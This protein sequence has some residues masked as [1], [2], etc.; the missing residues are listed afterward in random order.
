MA[1]PKTS[2]E[3]MHAL[4]REAG[5]GERLDRFI[6]LAERHTATLD[7]ALAIC[8]KY[9]GDFQHERI[10][11]Q[12]RQLRRRLMADLDHPCMA[13]PFGSLGEWG[14]NGLARTVQDTLQQALSFE[15]IRA[16]DAE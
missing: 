12:A 2:R 1:V 14:G 7:Q 10:A 9:P 8:A 5:D 16:D 13:S 15:R 3:R 11:K 6:A 4:I